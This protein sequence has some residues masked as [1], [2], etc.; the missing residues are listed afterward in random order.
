[1]GDHKTKADRDF[2]RK[3][4]EMISR[5]LTYLSEELQR[6]EDMNL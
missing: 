5:N 2:L 3:I 4:V 6:L 1:M